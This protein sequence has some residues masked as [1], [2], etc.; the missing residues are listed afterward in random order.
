L[1]R[2]HPGDDG[3]CT[4][5]AAE[6]GLAVAWALLGRRARPL[7]FGLAIAAPPVILLAANLAT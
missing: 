5:L 2:V 1:S 3:I 7:W 6:R 4:F